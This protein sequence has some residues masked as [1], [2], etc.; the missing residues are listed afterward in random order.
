MIQR[1]MSSMI[2]ACPHTAPR[3]LDCNT[4]ITFVRRNLS[5]FLD[6]W[7]TAAFQSSSWRCM[8][9]DDWKEHKANQWQQWHCHWVKWSKQKQNTEMI[10][11]DQIKCD[12][13]LQDGFKTDVQNLKDFRFFF[14]LSRLIVN[15]FSSITIKKRRR[16]KI[17]EQYSP[18]PSTTDQHQFKAVCCFIWSHGHK[19]TQTSQRP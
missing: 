16:R 13:K 11:L 15:V 10:W 3:L 4:N 6:E 9:T 14:I 1:S 8:T 17:G 7:T 19:H 18:L 12:W 5:T 2:H